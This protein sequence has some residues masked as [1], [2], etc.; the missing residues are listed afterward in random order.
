MSTGKTNRGLKLALA[1]LLLPACAGATGATWDLGRAL[2]AGRPG[3]AAWAF[4]AGYGLWLA[5]FAL[6]P[7]PTRTYVLGHE[8]TH[9]LWAW[10]MGARVSG[11]R[12]SKTGGQ[13]RTTKTNW[14][15][16]LAPY[17]FPFYAMLFL[18][19]F[20]IGHM[21]WDFSR[22]YWT[23]FFLVGLG[24]SFH[25]TFTLMVL[26]TVSQPDVQSQG[27]LFSAVVIYL[28]NLLTMT[29]T[30]T[31][32]SSALGWALWS[33]AFWENIAGSYMWTLDKFGLLWEYA[34][35]SWN[36]TR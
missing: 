34:V 12:V 35:T 11:L 27:T 29:V 36:H 24:W 33:R 2:L 25:V 10:L 18:A 17:F 23:L 20:L 8:L 19:G 6:L 28:M 22:H 13:V 4:G 30:A 9:A 3:G 1:I 32:L 5:V 26:I 16:T 15:I 21:I 7:K 31:L 14:A